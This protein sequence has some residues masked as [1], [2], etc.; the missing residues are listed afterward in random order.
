MKKLLVALIY[1]FDKTLC[2]KDM[3]EYGFIPALGMTADAFWR[4]VNA[5]TDREGMDSILA[6]MYLMAQKGREKGVCVRRS[7]FEGLGAGVKFFPGVTEWFEHIN[8]AAAALD[9]QIEHYIISSGLKEI[10]DGTAIAS[11]FKKIYACE[12]LYDAQDTVLWPKIA[13]NYTAKTQFLF[14]INKG[15]LDIDS[16]SAAHLNAF[17]PESRRRIPF[18]SMIYMGDG[19]TDVPCMKLVKS[20]GG[21]A[22]ALYAPEC[23]DSIARSLLAADRVHYAAPADYRAGQR[24]DTI[25]QAILRKLQADHVLRELADS[26]PV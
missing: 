23:G 10:I 9:I 25:V 20:H 6:Y 7:T 2:T 3:Q 18:K 11:Y 26:E 16:R 19:L 21:H 12:F 15:V 24:L 1:D 13:V 8:T 5:L 17:T 4:E 14:R 22:V